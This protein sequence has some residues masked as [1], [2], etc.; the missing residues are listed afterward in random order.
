MW[1]G[2]NLLIVKNR[3]PIQRVS[4]L[5]HIKESKRNTMFLEKN[6]KKFFVLKNNVIKNI[7]WLRMTWFLQI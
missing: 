2:F 7:Y 5:P 3:Q 4:Y 1:F 6:W